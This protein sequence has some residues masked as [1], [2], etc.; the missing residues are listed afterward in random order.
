[1]PNKG[2]I[3][4]STQLEEI[5]IA[6]KVIEES[7]QEDAV[8]VVKGYAVILRA[9]GDVLEANAEKIG[10]LII[11]HKTLILNCINLV[12]GILVLIPG[13]ESLQKDLEALEEM[14]KALV[15]HLKRK[16]KCQNEEAEAETKIHSQEKFENIFEQILYEGLN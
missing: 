12:E 14:D 2:E 1:M 6:K 4:M 16:H 9:A 7:S 3:L 5:Q 10:D 13:F 8:M 11:K 15:N